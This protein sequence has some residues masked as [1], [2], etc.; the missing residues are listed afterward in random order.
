MKKTDKNSIKP[1]EISSLR[2]G[3]YEKIMSQE[4]QDKLQASLDAQEIWT[5]RRP[6]PVWLP[7][8]RFCSETG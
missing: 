2:D 8:F 4:F 3:L 1:T 6:S 5:R 7:I